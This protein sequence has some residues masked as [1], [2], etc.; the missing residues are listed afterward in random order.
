M[1]MHNLYVPTSEN[2]MPRPKFRDYTKEDQEGKDFTYRTRESNPPS[3]ALTEPSTIKASPFSPALPEPDM[4]T[5]YYMNP[6]N[7]E[8]HAVKKW[9]KI[10]RRL[11][12][13][14]G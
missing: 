8:E 14:K 9:K 5:P 2:I 12:R 4:T 1:P 13:P 6:Y 10:D 7:K 11:S 3:R